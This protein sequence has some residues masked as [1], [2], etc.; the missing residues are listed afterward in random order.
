K[1]SI[2]ATLVE[3]DTVKIGP[4]PGTTRR[5]Q[6]FAM[7]SNGQTLFEVVDTPGFQEPEAM[8]AWLRAH[9][10]GVAS[11]PELI[12]RFVAEFQGSDQF[13][14]ECELLQPVLQGA[15]LIY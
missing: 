4:E 3:D 7:Q 11:R 8:L 9:D 14:D 12:K 2:I 6:K 15:H 1:S 10:K 5:C 13:V